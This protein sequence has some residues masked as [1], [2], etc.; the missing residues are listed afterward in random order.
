MRQLQFTSWADHSVPEGPGPLLA[1]ADLVR[2]QARGPGP[3]L[4]HCR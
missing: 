4:V 1:F 2:A 3:V